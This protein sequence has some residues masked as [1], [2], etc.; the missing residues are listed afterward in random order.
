MTKAKEI[1]ARLCLSVLFGTVCT[2][3]LGGVYFFLWLCN[4]YHNMEQWNGFSKVV[5]IVIATIT[6]ILWFALEILI[7]LDDEEDSPKSFDY[8]KFHGIIK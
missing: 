5:F 8:Y 7:L 2:I 6:I 3:W 4:H 1:L